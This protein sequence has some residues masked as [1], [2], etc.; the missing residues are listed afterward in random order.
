M[1]WNALVPRRPHPFLDG[2]A[3]GSYV[4]FVH[5]Y[6]CEA[7]EDVIVSILRPLAANQAVRVQG[8]RGTETRE[9]LIL[10]AGACPG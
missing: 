2:V 1:G 6:Y 4:Y 8:T 5:S 3:E 7:P 9:L 10:N